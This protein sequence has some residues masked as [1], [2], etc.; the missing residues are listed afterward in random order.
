MVTAVTFVQYKFYFCFVYIAIT[1]QGFVYFL[2]LITHTVIA[3]YKVSLCNLWNLCYQT[4]R[5]PSVLVALSTFSL[6]LYRDRS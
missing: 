2:S 4:P 6:F 5:F 3:L 1:H